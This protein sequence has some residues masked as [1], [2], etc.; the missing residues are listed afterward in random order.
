[1]LTNGWNKATIGGHIVRDNDISH[2]EQAGIVGSLGGAFS[3]ITGNNIHD[4]HMLNWYS[5]AE[6]AG[7]KLHGAIDV[8]I[9]HNHIYRCWRGIWLD[10]MAQ[11]T[12]VT[13]NLF[14]DN[15]PG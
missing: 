5:G 11:G 10:W 1:A 7:I 2:C 4:I 3:T 9:S 14:H 6:M 13:G 15:A 8:T 12:R